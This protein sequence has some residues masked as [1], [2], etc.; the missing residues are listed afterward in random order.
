MNLDTT[1]ISAPGCYQVQGSVKLPIDGVGVATVPISPPASGGVIIAVAP[2][3]SQRSDQLWSTT[4]GKIGTHVQ[5]GGLYGQAAHVA[6]QML[7]MPAD[8]LGCAHVAWSKAPVASVGTPVSVTG[9][10][11]DIAVGS[12]VTDKTGCYLPVAK[13]TMDADAWSTAA[14]GPRDGHYNALIAAPAALNQLLTTTSR[15]GGSDD[16]SGFYRALVGFAL[17]LSFTVL[18]AV[19][20]GWRGRAGPRRSAAECVPTESRLAGRRSAARRA[21]GA[22]R[23]ATPGRAPRR[24]RRQP[25]PLNQP[26]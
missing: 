8:P 9:D 14:V 5:V 18:A 12:G 24:E 2:V 4:P 10:S 1:A 19:Y 23:A 26:G 11:S 7:Y 21:D 16:L 15:S 22:A 25:A 3:V 20:I 13:V 17:L 6:V